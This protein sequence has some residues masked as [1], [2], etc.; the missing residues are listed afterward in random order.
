[1]QANFLRHE[2]FLGAV[3]A[4]LSVHPMAGVAASPAVPACTPEPR[5]VC[6]LSNDHT[7]QEESVT[8]TGAENKCMACACHLL[9]GCGC[10]SASAAA[11]P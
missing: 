5:K 6:K 9:P 11:K 2:G 10:T 1:M 3:G 7:A 8:M 4:F